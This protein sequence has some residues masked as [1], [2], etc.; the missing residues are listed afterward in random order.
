MELFSR[1]ELFIE[2]VRKQCESRRRSKNQEVLPEIERPLTDADYP[3]EFVERR[4]I[5]RMM[6][7]AERLIRKAA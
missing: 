2:S 3:L 5:E 7:L 1:D 6:Q 4:R